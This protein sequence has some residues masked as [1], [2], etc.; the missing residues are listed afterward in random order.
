MIIETDD[1]SFMDY[2]SDC[3]VLEIESPCPSPGSDVLHENE[4]FP[5]AEVLSDEDLDATLAARFQVP[6]ALVIFFAYLLTA[7]SALFA[8]SAARI[9]Y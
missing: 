6:I 7:F 9:W 2:D 1:E 4:D 8:D 5:S 3:V